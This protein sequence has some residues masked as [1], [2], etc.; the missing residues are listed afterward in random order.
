MPDPWTSELRAT[1]IYP[2]GNCN[3]APCVRRCLYA[4]HGDPRQVFGICAGTCQVVYR[5]LL[6]VVV[7]ANQQMARQF[8]IRVGYQSRR[9]VFAILCD[10]DD[11]AQ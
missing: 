5:Q 9:A 2:A 3:K 8:V 4:I 6:P 11:A 7:P 10:G 1:L